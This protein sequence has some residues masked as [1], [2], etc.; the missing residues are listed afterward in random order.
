[1]DRIKR[2]QPETVASIAII[3]IHQADVLLERLIERQKADFLA[4]GGIRE[5]MTRVRLEAGR[6]R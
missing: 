1:M 2:R 3:L 5:E 4:H 6:K